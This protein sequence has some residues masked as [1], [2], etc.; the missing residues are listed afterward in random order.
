M[1]PR[2]LASWATAVTVELEASVA[3]PYEVF[4]SHRRTRF[5]VPT[6]RSSI[7]TTRPARFLDPTRSAEIL[8]T[9]SIHK[10]YLT[11]RPVLASRIGS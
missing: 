8:D 2:A 1:C 5:L 10:H 4:G 9:T 7:R 11:S 3:G 6:G